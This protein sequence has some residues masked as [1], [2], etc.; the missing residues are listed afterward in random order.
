[1]QDQDLKLGLELS[2]WELSAYRR[3]V[4]KRHSRI[5]GEEGRE[6]I[7]MLELSA[8][9]RAGREQELTKE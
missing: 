8:L 3:G 7:S 9:Q 2:E 5:R 6:G 1:M 4:K